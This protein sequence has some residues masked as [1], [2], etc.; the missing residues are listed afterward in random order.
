MIVAMPSLAIAMARHAMRTQPVL[1]LTNGLSQEQ[2]RMLLCIAFVIPCET[3]FVQWNA[4]LTSLTTKLFIRD[5][6]PDRL[7]VIGED[8]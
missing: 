3:G 1:P 6:R 8:W 5:D 4:H 2:M 7:M